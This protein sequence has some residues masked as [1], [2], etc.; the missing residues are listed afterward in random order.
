MGRP[1]APLGDAPWAYDYRINEYWRIGQC[2]QH[3][4][5]YEAAITNIF[6]DTSFLRGQ[7][8]QV[9]FA[10]VWTQCQ[11]LN[12]VDAPLFAV[13]PGHM[14]TKASDASHGESPTLHGETV[15]GVKRSFFEAF[16][17]PEKEIAHTHLPQYV[18][19][20]G[21]YKL[22]VPWRLATAVPAPGMSGLQ[23][24]RERPLLNQGR[25]RMQTWATPSVLH[26]VSNVSNV[27][28]LRDIATHPPLSAST[29]STV[30]AT[31]PAL[32]ATQTTRTV[33]IGPLSNHT[34]HVLPLVVP[35]PPL[36]VPVTNPPK[37]AH[38]YAA[39]AV[40]NAV[41]TG[42]T[43]AV[44]SMQSMTADMNGL[45]TQSGPAVIKVHRVSTKGKMTASNAL[46]KTP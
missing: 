19:N 6:H 9:T 26:A 38:Q 24:A 29:A 8:L 41:V 28:G 40:L 20:K 43:P 46:P 1:E 36:V 13:G 21:P 30:L 32:A 35:A 39:A 14:S 7:L 27:L 31:R 10:P 44:A 5:S 25:G 4:A 3:R 34:S 15:P 12:T 33:P 22:G 16:R 18:P 2:F 17:A 37:A 45:E 42:A 11:P 23:A